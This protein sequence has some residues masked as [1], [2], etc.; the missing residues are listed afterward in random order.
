[1][2]PSHLANM[3]LKKSLART[4]LGAGIAAGLL[5]NPAPVQAT[6]RYA[7]DYATL[8]NVVASAAT[9]DTIEITANITV[10]AQVLINA[11]GLSFVG[12]SDFTISVPVPG[13]TSSGVV[14][15]NPSAFRVFSITASGLTNSFQN[16]TI[17]GGAPSGSGGA[18]LNGAGVDAMVK[19]GGG[20]ACGVSATVGAGAGVVTGGRTGAGG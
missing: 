19:P 8:T 13:L 6:T 14:N 11:K 3:H 5:M 15:N 17:V 4:F 2:N 20:S 9:G 1:M 12:N 10:G 18:I 7:G 16:L